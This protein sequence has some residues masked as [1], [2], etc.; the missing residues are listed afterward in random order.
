MEVIISRLGINGEGVTRLQGGEH[1][2]KVCFV[3]FALP[4][5]KVDIDIVQNKSKF[6][7]GK[8]NKIISKSVDRTEARCPYFTRC[9]GCDIQHLEITKQREFK[10]KKVI[11]ALRK[12][13]SEDK[14]K[15]TVFDEPFEYRNKMVF[16]VRQ[17]G[18]EKKIGMFESLSHHIIDIERCLLTNDIINKVYAI[19]KEYFLQSN[20]TAYNEKTKKGDIKYIVIREHNGSILVTIVSTKKVKLDEY[21]DVLCQE[22]GS[23]GLSNLISTQDTEILVGK[24]CQLY[25][26]NELNIKEFGVEYG[27]NNLGFLQVNNAMKTKMYTRVLDEISTDANVIDAYSGAGLLSAIIA[28][29]ARAV[30]GIEINESASKSAENLAKKNNLQNIKFVCDDVAKSLPNVLENCSNTTL[31]LDPPRSGCSVSVSESIIE[32]SDNIDKIIYISC[33]PATLARDLEYLCEK[34]DIV[35]VT[36]FDLFPQTK[37]IETLVVLERKG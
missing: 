30:V 34:F 18:N 7:K 28:G 11:D 33:N 22:F 4:N 15:P 35:S 26:L 1:D 31:V 6:C 2:N 5:E 19:S 16:A 10:Y 20:N 12:V 27:V 21:Y 32:N 9:G 14:V 3:D 25:G 29:K 23:V 13:A 24:Y 8:L 36:P 37:H 17:E